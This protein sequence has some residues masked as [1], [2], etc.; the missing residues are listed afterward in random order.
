[1]TLICR[2]HA[3]ENPSYVSSNESAASTKS[4]A[5]HIFNVASC[6]EQKTVFNFL[7][8]LSSASRFC[9]ALQFEKR[10]EWFKAEKCVE[11]RQH[12]RN[13]QKRLNCI[14]SSKAVYS[15]SRLL[16]QMLQAK[17]FQFES[18]AKPQRELCTFWCGNPPLRFTI[19][20]YN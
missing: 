3:C 1:M 17:S 16:L 2:C 10:S 20:V 6:Q 8:N 13:P 19:Q 7:F 9:F 4:L 11:I 12:S 15:L 14:K 5:C 18:E